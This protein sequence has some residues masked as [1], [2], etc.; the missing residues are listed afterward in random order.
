VSFIAPGGAAG[1]AIDGVSFVTTTGSPP[2]AGDRRGG[3]VN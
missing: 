1:K 3:Q 2:T